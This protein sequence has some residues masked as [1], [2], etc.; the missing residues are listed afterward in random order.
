MKAY[1]QFQVLSTGYVPNSIPPQ[2]KE[3]LKKPIDKLGSDGVYILDGRNSL[4][5][6]INDSI[7]RLNKI[8]RNNHIVSFK[9]VK[10]ERF[11]DNGRVIYQHKNLF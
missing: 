6:M 9:I 3:D 2:F 10:A 8:N 11:S 1:C 7:K 5:T 4:N